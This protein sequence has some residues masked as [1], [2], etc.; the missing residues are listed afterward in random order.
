[1]DNPKKKSHKVTPIGERRHFKNQSG[2]HANLMKNR[3]KETP[4]KKSENF[5]P[6]VRVG[7]NHAAAVMGT[8]GARRGKAG[9]GHKKPGEKGVGFIEAQTG[10]QEEGN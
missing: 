2:K 6:R 4:K 10:H 9:G 1:V 7:C 8:K 5:Q 3:L